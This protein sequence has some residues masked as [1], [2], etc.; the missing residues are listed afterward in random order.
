M[1]VCVCVLVIVAYYCV[2]MCE[3][4]IMHVYEKVHVQRVFF[5]GC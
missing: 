5:T 4:Y 3:W 1:S 2:C